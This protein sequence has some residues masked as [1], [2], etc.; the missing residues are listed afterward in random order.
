MENAVEAALGIDIELLISQARR[1][2]AGRQRRNLELVQV[3]MSLRRFSSVRR[4]VITPSMPL[5]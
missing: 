2:V 1:S 4:W 3:S 5:R